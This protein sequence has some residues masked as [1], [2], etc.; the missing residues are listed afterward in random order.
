[1]NMHELFLKWFYQEKWLEAAKE[2]SYTL[3]QF[4][5]LFSDLKSRVKFVYENFK[6]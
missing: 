5:S 4:N 6:L 3:L 1:M 2:N